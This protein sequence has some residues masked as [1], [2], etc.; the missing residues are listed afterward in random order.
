MIKQFYNFFRK[1]KG[2]IKTSDQSRVLETTLMPKTAYMDRREHNNIILP[3]QAGR[4]NTKN[5]C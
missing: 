5:H 2:Q 3:L 1:K 4:E